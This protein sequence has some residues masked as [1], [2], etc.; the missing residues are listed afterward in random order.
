MSALRAR[1]PAK[2]NLLLWLGPSRPDGLHELVSIM[3]SISLADELELAPAP[4][5]ARDLVDCAGVDG[6]NLAARALE[7]FRRASGWSAAP[8]RL[9]ILKRI[10]VAAGLGGGSAD[11]AAALR[12][13]ARAA[14]RDVGDMMAALAPSLG[15]DVPGQLDPG[16]VLVTGAGERVRRL[17]APAPA[18]LLVVPLPHRLSSASVFAQADRMG[19]SRS[20]GDLSARLGRL[21]RAL[22]EDGGLPLGLAGNDLEPAARALC[23][24]IEPALEAVGETGP[25]AALVTGSG[26][27]VVGVYPGEAGA[28]RAREGA[29]RLRGRFP[30]ACAA[31]PVESG[32]GA[33][34]PVTVSA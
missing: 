19:L 34:E 3:W 17:P 7:A 26:P 14:G 5:A 24:A 27:T 4:G 10:P 33:P 16:A 23:P 2:L 18:G 8:Q 31:T 21:E 20:P 13:A 6:P 25:A 15:A 28:D 12:L 22:K 29:D 11:A 1:A 30:G 32:F 9:T